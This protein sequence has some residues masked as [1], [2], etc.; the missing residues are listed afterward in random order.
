MVN[1]Q[2]F[3][4]WLSRASGCCITGAGDKLPPDDHACSSV[5]LS[6]VFT[7]VNSEACSIFRYQLCEETG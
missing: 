1:K 4:L 2:V 3:R 7:T 5:V 6:V